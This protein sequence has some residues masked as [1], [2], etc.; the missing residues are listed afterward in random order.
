M[1]DLWLTLGK[2]RYRLEDAALSCV[3]YRA[4]FG[5]SV[6]EALRR[7][8]GAAEREGVLVRMCWAMLP[9][10]GRPDLLT[11]AAQFR[12]EE[13]ALA[14]ALAARDALL[15]P[16]RSLDGWDDP[17][18]ESGEPFDEYKLLASL[19]LA[20]VDMGLLRELPLLHLLG[21]VRRMAALQD[22]ERRTYRKLTAAEMGR[23]YPRRK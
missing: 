21:L 7:P 22:P 3:R 16:D 17:G 8:M 15:R 23:I 20:R 6:V 13:T 2:E 18:E 11:I 10:A 5:E 19:S 14:Q 1:T 4:A 12:R 9:E